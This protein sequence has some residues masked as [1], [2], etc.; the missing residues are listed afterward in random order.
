MPLTVQKL[1][2]RIAELGKA[3]VACPHVHRSRLC[4]ACCRANDATA[5]TRR[6]KLVAA[7]IG[8]A[9]GADAWHELAGDDFASASADGAAGRFAVTLGYAAWGQLVAAIGG[10]GFSGWPRYRRF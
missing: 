4:R 8:P 2:V 9:M 6:C 1:R 3:V 7:R 10:H 5:T